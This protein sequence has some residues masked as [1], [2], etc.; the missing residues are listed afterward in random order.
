MKPLISELLGIE[1]CYEVH[2][3][4][5]SM[6]RNIDILSVK[7]MIDDPTTQCQIQK[8]GRLKFINSGTVII[9]EV[10]KS[11]LWI[12]TVYHKGRKEKQ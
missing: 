6:E 7:S 5:R 12:K 2:A 9:G 4:N 11:C 10:R 3:S 8:N 1:V